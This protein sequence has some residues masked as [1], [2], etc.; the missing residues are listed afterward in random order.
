M[1]VPRVLGE[2]E[3][4]GSKGLRLARMRRS[5]TLR[6]AARTW[7]LQILC[8]SCPF[9]QGCVR[10]SPVHSGRL[11]L[12]EHTAAVQGLLHKSLEEG[13]GLSKAAGLPS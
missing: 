7:V 13:E 1:A 8:D 3:G 9:E 11:G 5:L 10:L 4:S 6:L 12:L 2:V